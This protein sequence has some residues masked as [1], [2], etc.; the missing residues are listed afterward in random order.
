MLENEKAWDDSKRKVDDRDTDRPVNFGIATPRRVGMRFDLLF[1]L[2]KQSN[3]YYFTEL[4]TK[5]WDYVK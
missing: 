4:L 1:L 5:G 2:N 3:C